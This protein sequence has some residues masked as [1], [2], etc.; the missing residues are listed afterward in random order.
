MYK[1]KNY[2]FN[3]SQITISTGKLALL[4]ASSIT[5]QMGNTTI[6]VTTNI[7]KVDSEQDF[8]PLSIEYIEKMY[9][10]GAISGSRFQKR[11]GYP[12]E[13]AIIKARQVDHS[14]RSLFPKGF[15]KATS[16]II[17][18]LSFDEKNDPEVLAVLGASL[19]IMM[20]GLPYAGPSASVVSVIDANGGITINPLIEQTDHLA[21]LVV[22]G[23][24]NKFLSIEGWAKEIS[25]EQMDEMLRK[26][27]EK[28]IELNSI[29]RDFYKFV[30]EKDFDNAIDESIELPVSEDLI[31]VL[32]EKYSDEI[33]AALFVPEKSDRTSLMSDLKTKIHNE[34]NE[35][36]ETVDDKSKFEINTAIEYI[37]RKLLRSAVLNEEKRVSARTL[38]EI[39]PLSVEV[40]ILP[41]VHGSAL[42]S[43]G[44]TQSLSV[45]TLGPLSDSQELD[46]MEGASTKRFMHHYNFPPFSTGETGKYNYKPSRREI[47]HGAIGENALKNLVPDEKSFP[48]TIRVVSEILTSNG[49]TSM[50]ATCAAS[51]AL[52]AAGVPIKSAVAGIGVGLVSEDGN[53]DNYKLLMDIE[54]IEDFYGDMDFKVTGTAQGITAIQYENKLR[55]VKFEI[56]SE[57]LR[58]A[59][60]GRQKVLQ[61]MN[62]VI[63]KS[64]DNISPNAPVVY[65]MQIK[66]DQIGEL[67][68][69]GGKNIREIIDRA[70]DQFQKD[71]D[72]NIEDDGTVF[73]TAVN[74]SQLEFVKNIIL[75]QF[76]KPIIGEVHVGVVDKIMP[77]GVFV[78]VS[79]SITGL[80][81]VSE[82][83]QTNK[84]PDL[85]KIF[86]LGQ[87]INVKISKIEN[88][89]INFSLIGVINNADLMDDIET[90]KTTFS[91]DLASRN[92]SRPS[93]GMHS[94]R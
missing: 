62:D 58:W 54:G 78:N 14:I 39:R 65:S 32:T 94:R 21:E 38:D 60:K 17:T 61:V 33:K 43:R 52:M 18:V 57:A 20:A 25:D 87:R 26:S 49:S 16:V 64:R 76:K 34:W 85:E 5:V 92:N 55:G 35:T 81:H 31:N 10:R 59:N 40:D 27:M 7:S 50:A 67:I 89:K 72:I 15:K 84:N 70:K 13:E 93:G 68:G 36:H 12:S 44:L 82:I 3:G 22:S 11:E 37:A 30:F 45:V 6:L 90:H 80:L 66:K 51:M 9:A 19:S 47:G 63:R 71:C 29:Q 42:F 83:S 8:F 56:I 1:S 75:D 91:R 2:D 86:K 24:D 77:Y 79:N 23:V 28:I 4:S 74:Q 48:Y 53:E 69:P 88:N 46:D 73:I 41:Y